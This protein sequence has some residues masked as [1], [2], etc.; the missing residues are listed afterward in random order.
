MMRRV[1]GKRPGGTTPFR[2]AHINLFQQALWKNREAALHQ[3]Q[4]LSH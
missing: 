3:R 2:I 4:G 1:R